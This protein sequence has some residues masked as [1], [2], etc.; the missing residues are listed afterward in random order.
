M[1]PACHRC[2]VWDDRGGELSTGWKRGTLARSQAAPARGERDEAVLCSGGLA[3][4][5]I[6]S[7]AL[8][9]PVS[10]AQDDD[11]LALVLEGSACLDV[12]GQLLDLVGGDWVWLPAGTSHCLLSTVPGTRWLTVHHSAH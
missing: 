7:G 6:L 2:T 10:Y 8:V 9:K 3:V 1:P 12:E 4:H 5:H 11:E